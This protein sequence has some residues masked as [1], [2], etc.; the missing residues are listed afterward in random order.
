[1]LCDRDS[2]D[3]LELPRHSSRFAVTPLPA[4]NEGAELVA[5]LLYSHITTMS[6]MR[7]TLGILESN[8]SLRDSVCIRLLLMQPPLVGHPLHSD[9]PKHGLRR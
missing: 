2:W 7:W 1:M 4:L 5:N 8:A 3:V 6:F 9:W